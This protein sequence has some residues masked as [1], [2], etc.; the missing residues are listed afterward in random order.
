[1]VDDKVDDKIDDKIVEIF[2]DAPKYKPDYAIL[3]DPTIAELKALI[4][5]HPKRFL[6]PFYTGTVDEF[7]DFSSEFPVT[8][9]NPS[10]YD[11]LVRPTYL[12]NYPAESRATVAELIVKL[13]LDP[14]YSWAPN[15]HPESQALPSTYS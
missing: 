13:A 11:H 2:L 5:E 1:M 15:P 6:F 9:P 7:P 8:Y 14:A 10:G 12:G 3:F 4:R